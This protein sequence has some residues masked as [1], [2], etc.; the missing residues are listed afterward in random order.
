MP[1]QRFT[2]FARY[3]M[4]MPDDVFVMA[5]PLLASQQITRAPVREVATDQRVQFQLKGAEPGRR[6]G[7]ALN[8]FTHQPRANGH[9]GQSVDDD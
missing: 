9:V 6:R 1:M 3:R 8:R 2:I 4:G 5:A 7:G